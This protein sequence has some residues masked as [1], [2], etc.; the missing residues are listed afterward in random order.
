MT[1]RHIIALT[2]GI[3]LLAGCN[4]EPAT[5]TAAPEATPAVAAVTP[6]P[7]ECPPPKTAYDPEE[8]GAREAPLAVPSSIA[9]IA[10][11]DGTNLAVTTL[12]GGQVCQDVSWM[13]NLGK[14]TQTH[15]DGRFVAIGYDAYEAFGTMV[16]DRAGKGAMVDTGNP[17]AFSPSGRLLAGL[18]LTMSGYGGLESFVIWNVQPDGLT[19]LHRMAEADTPL[20]EAMLEF[21]ATGWKGEDC[22]D[23]AA[24]A[25]D[26]L[27]AAEWER[28]KARR[29]P[30]HA[31]RGNG[32][33]ITRGTCPA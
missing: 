21:V 17:P 18:E 23:I 10:A 4:P 16:F 20:S 5:D 30:F 3:A 31:A 1:S 13:Y 24:F 7:A 6:D 28:A 19:E 33:R 26:D 8:F 27:E 32:W 11:T 9:A 2:A 15:G 12:G 22:L 14:D 29:T 25:S